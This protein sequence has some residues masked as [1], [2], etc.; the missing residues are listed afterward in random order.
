MD[1]SHT[2][3]KIR[4]N[5]FKSDDAAFCKRHLKLKDK[6]FMEH[7]NKPFSVHHKLTQDHIYLTSESKMRNHLAEDVLNKEMFHLM[8]L[9]RESLGDAGSKLDVTIELL[10]NTSV[11]IQNFRDSR[12]I[13]PVSDE[14]LIE[15]MMLWYGLFNGKNQ[16]K[17][18]EK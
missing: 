9:Y 10:Q 7:F 8:K 15:I 6:L 12:P 5:I 2:L 11:L 14:R 3:K 4:N 16:L 13:T 17:K 18:I 1:I